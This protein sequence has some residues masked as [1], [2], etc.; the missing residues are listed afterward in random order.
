MKKD[1]LSRK[2]F[3]K[4]SWAS[5][6]GLV[7]AACKI[8]LDEE[9]IPTP[10]P[11]ATDTPT[12]EPQKDSAPAVK[13]E[14]TPTNTPSETPVPCLKLL[15]PEDDATLDA[16]GKVIFSWEAMQGA[17]KY[18]IEFT[19][20]TGQPVTF[21]A[22]ETTHTRYLESFPLSG[23]F[24]WKVTALDSNGNIICISEAFKFTKLEPAPKEDSGGDSPNS[25]S[26]GSNAASFSD[27]GTS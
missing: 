21:E 12:P 13:E 16:I 15:T 25:T 24:I 11:T 2:D 14:P 20:P 3:L 9:E 5:L 22:I 1:P 4:L 23:E 8:E 6:W 19:L 17:E 7:L 10:A 27:A 18:E 26:I